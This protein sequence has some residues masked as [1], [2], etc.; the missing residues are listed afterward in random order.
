MERVS[1]ENITYLFGNEV[2]VFGSNTAGRHG[3]GAARDALKWGA[4]SGKGEGFHG[5]TY[6]IPTKD[7]DLKTLP[8]EKIKL[9]VG[10]FAE[11]ARN[12]QEKIFQVTEIGC[13][14]AGYKPED[15]APLFKEAAM[16]E[17]VLLPKRFW[18]VLI[19]MPI[20]PNDRIA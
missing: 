10:E 17:N 7:R 3:K 18:D 9:A 19:S 5:M 6:A 13:G 8:I 14:L 4:R 12:N 15:I 1:R 20:D 16:L 11:F 2:F